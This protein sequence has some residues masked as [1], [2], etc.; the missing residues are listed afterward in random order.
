M[1]ALATRSFALAHI[2]ERLVPGETRVQGADYCGVTRLQRVVRQRAAADGGA[3]Q[4]PE[5]LWATLEIA[6]SRQPPP[7]P[8]PR[9]GDDTPAGDV[10]G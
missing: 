10:Q 2:A 4:A 6:G 5:E 1:P 8:Q 3:E 9:P 7:V